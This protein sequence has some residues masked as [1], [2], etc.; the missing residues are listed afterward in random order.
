MYCRMLSVTRLLLTG[1]SSR[2]ESVVAVPREFFAAADRKAAELLVREVLRRH[3]DFPPAR[4]LL[5]AVAPGG[6]PEK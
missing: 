5:A 6:A 4:R 3:E 2:A 1:D